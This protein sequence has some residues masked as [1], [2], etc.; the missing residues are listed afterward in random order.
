MDRIL[1][2]RDGSAV[3]SG[4]SVSALLAR[5]QWRTIGERLTAS[6]RGPRLPCIGLDSSMT[7]TLI[8]ASASPRRRQLLEEAGYAFEVD[9]SDVR[10]ARPGLG[11]LAGRVRRAP[12]LAEGDGRRH[13]GGGRA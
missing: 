8:L 6:D 10:R 7:P 9:P 5:G 12:G 2:R 13:A 11:D 4:W 1:M 3:R